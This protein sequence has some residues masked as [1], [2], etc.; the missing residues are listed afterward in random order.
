M[1][2]LLQL[3]VVSCFDVVLSDN[4]DI[5][6]SV[7]SDDMDLSYCFSVMSRRPGTCTRCSHGLMHVL[8][9]WSMRNVSA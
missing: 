7:Q 6:L 8:T 1:L 4:R 3:A 9:P 5:V 2:S